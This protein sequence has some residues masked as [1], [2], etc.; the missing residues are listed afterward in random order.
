MKILRL[1]LRA[2][3]PFTDLA[4]D[5]SQGNPGL[6][7]IYGPN[8]A[9]KS[10]TLRAVEQALF[11]IPMQSDDDFL[12]SY[13]NLR[14]GATLA[15]CDGTTLAFLRRKAKTNSLLAPDNVATLPEA[16]LAPF[17]GDL[18]REQFRTMFGIDHGQLVLGGQEIVSGNGSVG[19]L[20]FAAGS[21]IADLQSIHQRLQ[22]EAEEL[23][24]SRGKNQTINKLLKDLDEARKKAKRLQLPHEDWQQHHDALLHAQQ[25]RQAV[26]QEL[27]QRRREQHRLDRLKRA[28]PLLAQRRQLRSQRE[29][30]GS[31]VLLPAGFAADRRAVVAE[32]EA[33]RKTRQTAE[34]DL[35]RIDA[36][37]AAIDLPES[38]L[39]KARAI[40]EMSQTTLGSYRKAQRD[41]PG[42][43]GEK[44]Q[45]EQTAAQI[46]HQ[47]RPE[48]TLEMVGPL[49]LSTLEQVAIRDLA[50]SYQALVQGLKQSQ[51]Q[52][53]QI[54]LQLGEEE[55]ELARVE[56]PRSIGP[57]AELLRRVQKEGDLESSAADAQAKL[58]R[59]RQQATVELSRL[60]CWSGSLADLERLPV[61][62]AEAVDRFEQEFADVARRIAAT[63]ERQA[64]TAGDRADVERQ[65]D[66][67]RR[68]GEVPTEEDLCAARRLRDQGWQWV[69]AQWQAKAAALTQDAEFIAQFP[70][71]ADLAAAYEAA[72]GK[73][74]ECADRLRREAH[75]VA[76][77][78]GLLA[79]REALHRQAAT[80]QEQLETLH[81]QQ[82]A[83]QS[84]WRECWK[85]AA[86]DPRSPRE[87]RAWLQSF[88]RLVE[89]AEAIR[90]GQAAL[91]DLQRCIAAHAGQLQQALAALD[92][93]AGEENPALAV[94]MARGQAA[95]ERIQAAAVRREQLQRSVRQLQQRLVAARQRAQTAQAE[96]E[97]W[98]QRWALALEPLGF[99][100]QTSPAAANAVLGQI[101]EMFAAL[102][103][104]RDKQERIEGILRE[105]DAFRAEVQEL[106]RQSAPD[107]ID[108]P[109]EPAAETLIARLKKAAIEQKQHQTLTQQRERLK[110]QCDE[111]KDSID[112]LSARLEVMC[113]DAGGVQADDLPQAERASETA[114]RVDE[115]L[116]SLETQLF[117]VA[118]GASIDALLA[119]AEGVLADDLP[120]RI[121]QIGRQV[122]QL[123]L[124]RGELDRTIGGEQRDLAAMQS[125]DGAADAAAE[126]QELLARLEGEALQY[127]RLRLASA[128]LR[129]GIESYRAKNEGPVLRRASEL[130]AQFTLG[131]FERLVAQSD[132][133]QQTLKGVR[134]N[135]AA[136]VPGASNMVDL[137]GMS[138]GTAD[139]LFLALRLASLESHL[140]QREPIPLVVDDILISFDDQ[141]AAAALRALAQLAG[142]TQILFFTHHQ[143][144]VD[145]ARTT[146][147]AGVLF[148]HQ[149]RP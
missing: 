73:A 117:D 13:Q 120:G 140:D 90:N 65:I 41:L 12:H 124:E 21:G 89:Q 39:A 1:D 50:G 144:L 102:H 37:L 105:A 108:G 79:Q 132:G 95:K 94:L 122:E 99:N 23:Y 148:V 6:H 44:E 125:D 137:H 141:R 77:L 101:N 131:R 36:Q 20:L 54:E 52:I 135:G 86:I 8:E 4:L 32:L 57:L 96:L 114:L 82:V 67:S 110:R 18:N 78:A 58:S 40:E 136:A 66:Q 51:E 129:D 92:E 26:E 115:R 98:R 10:T 84:A 74:D 145:L 88:R 3:G 68:E 24:K 70:P 104:A 60:S 38:L 45:S 142:K 93:P 146:L 28:L 72:V 29:E 31:V 61:P 49:Q 91:D 42:L 63:E 75:R 19:Q 76:N 83:V 133:G 69:R 81:R 97:Q 147:D 53:G 130:F 34:A 128:V 17:L 55:N 138:E 64:A 113:R 80:L 43:K 56:E 11:G 118:A 116:A 48:L 35:A 71:A 87:M 33:A 14:I 5:L 123:E 100:D 15:A 149:L 2:F 112:K 134:C 16:A 109:C 46:L 103:A 47:I 59:A 139:Q 27:Q 143:H 62:G 111:T 121:E 106:V 127:V 22:S 126:V 107:L 7:V 25:R 9:G 30:L 119:E 85:P